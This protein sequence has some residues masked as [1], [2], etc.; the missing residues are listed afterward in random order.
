VVAATSLQ[1]AEDWRTT[2]TGLAGSAT[3]WLFVTRLSVV[4]QVPSFVVV[5]RPYAYG[6][7]TE[8]LSWVLNRDELLAHASAAGL[9]LEREFIAGAPTV[10]AGGPEPS[11][12]AGFLFKRTG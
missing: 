3:R 1:Y 6:Y 10:Y 5:Q 8:Y 2:L 11:E 12:T 4:R 9:T 7:Q